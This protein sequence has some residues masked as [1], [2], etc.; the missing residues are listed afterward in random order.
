[1]LE[2]FIRLF[3]LLITA[4]YAFYKLSNR[5]PSNISNQIILLISS[6]FTC[7]FSTS[8]FKINQTLRLMVTFIL[9]FL[10]MKLIEKLHIIPTYTTALFSY[11]FSFIIF[12]ISIVITSLGL[13]PF[14]CKSYEIPWILIR[15]LIGIV[16]FSL[17]YCCFHIPRLQKGMIFLYS[18]PSGNT[19]FTICIVIFMLYIIANQISDRTE[20][21]TFTFFSISI[22]SGF[23]LI[24]WWNY[25]ITQTYRKY[26]KKNE[27]DSLNLL[28]EERNQEITYLRSENEKLAGIIHKDNK[29]IP[30]LSMAIMESYETNTKLD[31]SSMDLDSSLHIKL[32][33]LYEERLEILANYQKEILHLPETAFP[34]VNAILSYMQ[35][36]SLKLKIPYQVMLFDD[37]TGTIPDRITEE[38]FTHMLSDLL[39]NAIN[40][41]KDTPSASIQIY[42]GIINGISTIKIYNTGNVFSVETLKLLGLSRHTTHADTGGSGIGLMDIWSLK[43]KYKATL[44]IDEILDESVVS[45]YT[46]INILFNQKNHYIV[47]SNRHKELSTY[48][49]RPDIII[50]SK[51]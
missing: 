28:L 40:A 1:M 21:I 4:T 27:I 19:G 35:S 51:E 42:L 32:K 37:L 34:S 15:I 47:Q 17:T 25:H 46:C 5:K 30:A 23:L 50:L 9:F 3:F 16:Q 12:Y 20:A 13:L 31:L 22:L 33:Q 26:L 24:Y 45:T 43:E 41:C 6:I 8:F 49:N 39:A 38:D 7:A 48:I 18:L 2:T 11:A 36:E 44:L 10:M 29:L 14:Y